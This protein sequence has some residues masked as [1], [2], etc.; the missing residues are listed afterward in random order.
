MH[1]E[2]ILEQF[3]EPPIQLVEKLI[4]LIVMMELMIL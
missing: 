4:E 1:I 3:I 2:A